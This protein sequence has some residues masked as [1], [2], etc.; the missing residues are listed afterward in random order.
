MR[1]LI[2]PQI[3][4]IEV[5]QL[6]LPA[7]LSRLSPGIISRVA[8]AF[9]P[10]STN[11]LTAGTYTVPIPAGATYCQ[12]DGY[13]AGQNGLGLTGNRGGGGGAFAR[14][15][16]PVAGHTAIYITVPP[17]STSAI[18]KAGN[19]EARWDN[20]SGEL[21]MRADGPEANT[22]SNVTHYGGLAENCIGDLTYSG[23]ATDYKAGG[24]GAGPNGAGLPATSNSAPG[25]GNGGLAGAGGNN[26]GGVQCGGGGAQGGLIGFVGGAGGVQLSWT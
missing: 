15:T 12:I 25:A 20:A 3:E 14:R 11:Y 22:S 24:G 4:R 13:A 1:P 18:T 16:V 2:R 6:W 10:Y 21:I 17:G 23:G 26:S 9:S 5:P 19:A 7:R 8:S